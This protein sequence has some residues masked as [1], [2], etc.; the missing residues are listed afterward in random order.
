MAGASSLPAAFSQ[1]A[2]PAQVVNVGQG[3]R[4]MIYAQGRPCAAKKLF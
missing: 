4:H 1:Q 2:G 3:P